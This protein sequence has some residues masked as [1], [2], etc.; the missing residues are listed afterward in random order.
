MGEF[1]I[2]VAIGIG[3]VS[4][5]REESKHARYATPLDYRQLAV[6]V[7]SDWQGV[8]NYPKPLFPPIPSLIKLH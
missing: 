5:C 6:P 8:T 1:G 7:K 3:L 4:A 2:I